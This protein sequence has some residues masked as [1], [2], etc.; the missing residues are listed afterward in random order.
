MLDHG[1]R[2]RRRDPRQG[3]GRHAAAARRVAPARAPRPAPAMTIWIV[4]RGIVGRRLVRLLDASQTRFHDPRTESLP[5][6]DGDIAVLCHPD[7][8]APLAEAIADARRVGRDGRRRLRRRPGSGAAR[9]PFESRG[10]DVGRRRRARHRGCRVCWRV[11][12][13]DSWRRST[14]SMSRSTARPAR[15]APAAT[16][17]RSRGARWH[18]TTGTG[19]TTSAAAAASCVGFPSR[20]GALDCYR[21][22]IAD[23]LLLHAAFPEVSRI[24]ARRSARR[25]DRFT[26][27]LPMLSPPHEEGGVGALRVELRGSNAT[28]RSRVPDRGRRG[29]RRH[30]RCG[31]GRR[32]RARCSTKVGCQRGLVSP[33]RNRCPRW[34]LW[35]GSRSYG[36]RL[37]EFTGVSN[38]VLIAHTALRGASTSSSLALSFSIASA[39]PLSSSRNSSPVT[40]SAS[41]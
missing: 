23:P 14:R 16:T 35:N 29:T 32:L 31:D 2:G 21:A 9:A 6:A 28:G 36:I 4:G 37:Q 5:V 3:Q 39:R 30:R 7:R 22:D 40:T 1:R 19:P 11:I 18:G 24:S 8:H 12:S 10:H 27:R 13:P 15:R 25:R 33:A 26:A 34:T 20:S 41:E 38:P 17:N